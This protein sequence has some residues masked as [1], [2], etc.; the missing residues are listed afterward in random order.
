MTTGTQV[1]ETGVWW[2]HD[3]KGWLWADRGSTALQ[4]APGSREL[5]EQ[6][7]RFYEQDG[8]FFCAGHKRWEPKP[9]VFRRF[10]GV[11]CEEAAEEYKA[12]NSRS[13][14]ICRRPIWDCY[15]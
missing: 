2:E 7:V 4:S 10:A 15:C 5:A 13:C 1:G 12:A 3:P 8:L 11:Y 14:H 9:H 6:Y